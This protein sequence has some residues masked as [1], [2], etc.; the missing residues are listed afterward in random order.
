MKKCKIENQQRASAA[1]REKDEM[2]STLWMET[3]E[4]AI[5]NMAKIA[6]W[7]AVILT[8]KVFAVHA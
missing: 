6:A 5:R 8:T 2:R 7:A 4:H 1:R 3:G